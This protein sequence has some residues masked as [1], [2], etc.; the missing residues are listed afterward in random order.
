MFPAI[1]R[2]VITHPWQTIAAW[3][4]VAIVVILF[5]PSLETYTTANQQSFLPSSFQSSKAQA[6][7]TKYF[8]TQSGA[9][10]SLVVTRHDGGQ[11]TPTDQQKAAALATSLMSDHIAGLKAVQVTPQLA[12]G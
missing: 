3:L 9:T 6:V 7:G 12:L 10:G 1:A 2:W 4:V 5:S 8:P 11:L